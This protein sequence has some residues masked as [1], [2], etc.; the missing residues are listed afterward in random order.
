MK[1]VGDEQLLDVDVADAV[2]V[3]GVER[4]AEQVEAAGDPSAGAGVVTGVDDGD[5]PRLRQSTSETL[6]DVGSV[7]GGQHEVVDTAGGVE[8]H[9]VAQDRLPTD[10]QQR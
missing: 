5:V 4:V 6:D 8:V 3:G 7:A 9:D 2:A 10:L 1:L